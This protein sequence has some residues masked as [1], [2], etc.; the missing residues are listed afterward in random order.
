MTGYTPAIYDIVIRTLTSSFPFSFQ[1]YYV[2]LVA[3][4]IL[5]VD[6]SERRRF[7]NTLVCRLLLLASGVEP[8]PG[9]NDQYQHQSGHLKRKNKDAKAMALVAND[10]K[11]RKLSF[12]FSS[13]ESTRSTTP[14]VSGPSHALIASPSPSSSSSSVLFPPLS[15]SLTSGDASPA[16]DEECYLPLENVGSSQENEEAPSDDDVR[17]DDDGGVADDSP[18]PESVIET[19]SLH[20][21]DSDPFSK[22]GAGPLS[23]L[24]KT[25]LI[26]AHPIQPETK[27]GCVVNL[28]FDKDRI[29]FQ[30]KGEEKR[31]WL[32]YCHNRKKIFCWI[33]H[34]FSSK[35]GGVFVNGGWGTYAQWA[36]RNCYA[37]VQKHEQGKEHTDAAMAFHAFLKNAAV[38]QR[39]NTSAKTLRER[40]VAARRE[41]VLRII[42]IIIFLAK[43]GSSFR[44]RDNEAAYSLPMP[45][46][47]G[48]FLEE[49]KSRAMY[50]PV[51]KDHLATVVEASK[52]RHDK[53]PSSQ[54]RGS[55]VTFLSKNTFRKLLNI[56]SSMVLEIIKDRINENG[57]KYSISLD[58]CQDLSVKEQLCLVGRYVDE[59]GPVEALLDISPATLT[60]GEALL[61]H[62][63][64]ILETLGLLLS[65]LVGYSFDGAG[66]MSGARKGL[67]ARLKELAPNSVY[68]HC[69]AHVLN[70]ELQ[71]SCNT[72]PQAAVLF[73]LLRDTAT[74]ISESYKRSG[75]WKDITGF[76]YSNTR[77]L[78]KFGK[79]RWWAKAK[80]CNR[81]FISE[82]TLLPIIIAVLELI[83][84][85]TTLLGA[86]RS[87][88]NG[89]LK[90]WC[91]FETLAVGMLF[92]KIFALSGPVSDYLQ[93]T[94]LD[95][96]QAARLTSHLIPSVSAIDVDV[97]L[98]DAKSLA[99]KCNATLD[100]LSSRHEYIEQFG[101]IEARLQTEHPSKRVS[102]VP[103]RLG[104]G[105][106]KFSALYR[107]TLAH[108]HLPT[109][110]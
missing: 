77:L 73:N 78:V 47:H 87:T 60:T 80:A 100:S 24:E 61:N 48:N 96:V 56:I 14:E 37:A 79:T 51:L 97:V 88:V 38:D 32:S 1:H 17:V 10:P 8:N 2:S 44:G 19:E 46:N 35:S 76:L 16:V 12:S 69:Y 3:S 42:N 83:S 11:Q 109:P 72:V 94:Q 30:E 36:A 81:I 59:F 7:F 93:N 84:N 85:D 39:L 90:K 23:A 6:V 29:Y 108:F 26:S 89:D 4:L 98:D 64:K 57:G 9:P 107:S 18:R 68:Q 71:K 92:Q 101:E 45:C 106:S 65:N 86:T 22:F 28:P 52:A 43:Q 66:N 34:G 104:E 41:V 67:Q 20:D 99:E 25:F 53:N 63:V 110:R 102:V 58:G 82:N 103:Q 40:Q 27:P 95:H 21:L 74:I 105:S 33:C 75:L 15:P 49:V 62:V 13:P 55:L 5:L 91:T 70:L 31:L 54:G 50:D